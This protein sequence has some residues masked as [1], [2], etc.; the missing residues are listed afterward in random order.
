[1]T[2]VEPALLKALTDRG[3]AWGAEG[4]NYG[5][6]VHWEE[7]SKE[8]RN[9]LESCELQLQLRARRY[10]SEK[11]RQAK[12]KLLGNE[13]MPHFTVVPVDD[14]S[15]SNYDSLE[16]INCVD[17]RDTGQDGYPGHGDTLSSDGKF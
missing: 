11:T 3:R 16:G 7:V 1:M 6:G 9:A 5:N 8:Q 15:H 4:G 2:G 12:I 17:Y 13:N 14:N 10:L